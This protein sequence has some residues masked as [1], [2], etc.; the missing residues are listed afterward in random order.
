M[1]IPGMTL[2]SLYKSPS[3]NRHPVDAGGSTKRR[4]RRRSLLSNEPAHAFHGK[5]ILHFWG[6][7]AWSKCVGKRCLDVRKSY[8]QAWFLVRDPTS[9]QLN[10]FPASGKFTS[11]HR[12]SCRSN[13]Q[14]CSSQEYSKGM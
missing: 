3:C 6:I 4:S 1:T 14:L 2:G 9:T 11:V 12:L 7:C 5:S 8:L 10:E 13:A